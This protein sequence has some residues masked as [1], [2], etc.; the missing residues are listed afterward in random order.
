M[1]TWKDSWEL[2]LLVAYFSSTHPH[3]LCPEAGRFPDAVI[4]S[5]KAFPSSSPKCYAQLNMKVVEETS[6]KQE[7]KKKKEREKKE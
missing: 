5:V 3:V 6:Q 7:I 1:D 4:S 2:R